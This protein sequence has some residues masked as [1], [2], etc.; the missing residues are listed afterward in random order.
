MSLLN[1]TWSVVNCLSHFDVFK[2]ESVIPMLHEL[3]IL[4]LLVERWS[5]K[6]LTPSW[7]MH[8]LGW[9]P[10]IS[11]ILIL[12]DNLI[13]ACYIP[14]PNVFFIETMINSWLVSVRWIC[15]KR[16]SLQIIEVK[17]LIVIFDWDHVS[18]TNSGACL[19]LKF[20]KSLVVVILSEWDI[21]DIVLE[22]WIVD[23]C[24]MESLEWVIKIW[25]FKDTRSKGVK[26]ELDSVV[27]E[28]VIVLHFVPINIWLSISCTKTYS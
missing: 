26:S 7:K 9:F 3:F 23:Y 15:V 20:L 19:W 11:Q 13:V 8:L 22:I 27:D 16:L 2:T 14:C 25:V 12:D 4:F 28:L 5:E 21:I 10:K 1:I 17:F 24:L 6:L 18:I